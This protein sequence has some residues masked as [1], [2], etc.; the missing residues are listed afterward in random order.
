MQLWVTVCSLP[1]FSCRRASFVKFLTI[2]NLP[3]L[4]CSPSHTGP[5]GFHILFS[6]NI[7]L[8]VAPVAPVPPLLTLLLQ[9]KHL[10]HPSIYETPHPPTPSL[11]STDFLWST[12]LPSQQCGCVSL[13]LLCFVRV[14][15]LATRD[16]HDGGARSRRAPFYPPPPPMSG[17]GS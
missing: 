6:Y 13:P 7:N 4:L 2:Q 5:T 15:L 10:I 16:S 1:S 3:A 17:I 9:S 8:P 11:N 12:C 14:G